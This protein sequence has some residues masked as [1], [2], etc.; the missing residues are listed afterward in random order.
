[1]TNAPLLPKILSPQ[2]WEKPP[3]DVIKINIDAASIDSGTFIRVIA[4]DWR[5]L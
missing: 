4:W 1:M 2:R 3:R 5:G